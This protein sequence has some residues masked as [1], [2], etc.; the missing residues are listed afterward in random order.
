VTPL[1]LVAFWPAAIELHVPQRVFVCL[2][3]VPPRALTFMT[4]IIFACHHND[5]FVQID[6]L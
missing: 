4:F 5:S 1:Q 2:T 6:C 3:E